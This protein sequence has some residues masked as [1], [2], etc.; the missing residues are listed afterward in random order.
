MKRPLSVIGFTMLVSLIV[1]C[2]AN[3]IVLSVSVCGLLSLLALIF[4]IKRKPLQSSFLLTICLSVAF[5]CVFFTA[6]E[7]YTYRPALKL[8]GNNT[9]I[10]AEITD[11]PSVSSKRYHI[12]AKTKLP[13]SK[14]QVNI[15][16]SLPVSS[17]F[18]DDT[19]DVIEQ[20]EIGDTIKFKGNIYK[21]GSSYNDAELNF[22]SK[23]IFLGAYPTGTVSL[24]KATHNN[25]RFYILSVRQRIIDK[26]LNS[27]ES[28]IASVGISVLLG[29]KSYLEGD[30]YTSFKRAGVSHIMAVSGL[31]LS[32]W[33]TFM[34]SV[35]D[36]MGLNKRRLSFILILFVLF[37]MCLALFSSSVTRAGLLLILYLF[38][39]RTRNNADSL[40]SLG[41]AAIVILLQNPFASLNSAFLLSFCSTLAL[42]TFGTKFSKSAEEKINSK[43]HQKT[44]SRILCLICGNLIF[45]ISVSVATFPILAVFF[46][47]ISILS[48]ITNL[49]F[50]P[51]VAPM[52]IFF[53]L[54]TAFS[55]IPIIS[56]VFKC[57]AAILCR[58]CIY[59]AKLMS[60]FHLSTIKLEGT[61]ALIFVCACILGFAV[62]M[63]EANSRRK[64]KSFLP[65]LLSVLLIVTS[66]FYNGYVKTQ[67]VFIKV[68]NVAD[69]LCVSVSSMN[70]NAL[71][72]AECNDYYKTF[73]ASVIEKADAVI[74]PDTEKA[75]MNLVSDLNPDIICLQNGERDLPI[76]LRN[77]ISN[78]DE[79]RFGKTQI[80][81]KDEVIYLEVY[82]IIIKIAD[83]LAGEADII[84]EN[85]HNLSDEN[86]SSIIIL[87]SAENTDNAFSTALYSDI[88]IEI[89]PNSAYSIRGE[90][91]WRYLMKKN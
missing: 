87:S 77:I 41:F 66:L 70:K 48:V 50:F 78:D 28:E 59:I 20:L 22:K 84:I 25:L 82:G 63:F 40:N 52:I 32:I 14:R 16:L 79:I 6:F 57:L 45:S 76:N 51:V 47:E 37:V 61:S 58:Y 91:S 44:V 60:S 17:K 71:L 42:V 18:D 62:L 9:E 68:H 54:F 43:V 5:S 15:R 64:S 13:N 7:Y 85:Q 83:T 80:K 4:C 53:G 1:L 36:Y 11:Y 2:Y 55:Y 24:V 12:T 81:I 34:M 86:N 75:N 21:L 19:E 72:F 67:N 69:G 33:V 74:L 35:A 26:L 39:Y 31:H 88:T 3:S 29:D 90:N 30:T 73:V 89:K 49:L 27:F 23:K 65:L 10:L 46:K 38:G 56:G 8:I